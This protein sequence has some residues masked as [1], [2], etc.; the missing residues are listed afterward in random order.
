[1]G[2]RVEYK[3]IGDTLP[4]KEAQKLREKASLVGEANNG[5]DNVMYVDG[6]YYLVSEGEQEHEGHVYM[7]PVE[8]LSTEYYEP[9]FSALNLE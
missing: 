2:C 7:T 5:F 8:I 4:F 1:M 3:I 6:K 9:V